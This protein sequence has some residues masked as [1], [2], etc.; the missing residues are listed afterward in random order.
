M[1]TLSCG[2]G[3]RDRPVRWAWAPGLRWQSNE[4]SML[5]GS[6][7]PPPK[8]QQPGP[9]SGSLIHVVL[10]LTAESRCR[11][12]SAG[13]ALM[14]GPGVLSCSVPWPAPTSKHYQPA[15]AST[16]TTR[17]RRRR[18]RP[19]RGGEHNHGDPTTTTCNLFGYVFKRSACNQDDMMHMTQHS[20]A[21]LTHL[22]FESERGVLTEFEQPSLVANYRLATALS[23]SLWQKFK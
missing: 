18:P 4:V 14:F 12:G 20:E 17:R 10:M 13:V 6:P 19:Q 1:G 22:H 8:Q 16:T 11:I 2:T 7:A 5:S 9:K 23:K 3:S 21:T 15:A